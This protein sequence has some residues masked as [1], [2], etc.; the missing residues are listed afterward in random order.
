MHTLAPVNY[1][2]HGTQ[3]TAA[4]GHL[5]FYG[6]YIMIIFTIIS[7][8]MPILRG[9]PHGNC[10]NAQNRE[11]KA[12]WMMNIGMLGLTL[13]LTTAGIM[14]ILDLRMGTE[15]IGFMESQ[16]SIAGVYMVRAGFG[17]LVFLGLMTYFTSF[18]IAEPSS[19]EANA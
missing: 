17:L 2:T 18:F 4:H 6:A 12:F 3:L 11:L 8:A 14:Q 1:F 10:Q 19:K 5:S 15:L 7:Y 9:R 16:A 13:S